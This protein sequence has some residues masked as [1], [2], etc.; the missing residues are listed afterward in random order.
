MNRILGPSRAEGGRTAAT[1]ESS[2]DVPPAPPFYPSIMCMV[3]IPI[4]KCTINTMQSKFLGYLEYFRLYTPN[5]IL[6]E[7][8]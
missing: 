6:F 7:T 2:L 4:E 8:T 5:D 3:C 1:G